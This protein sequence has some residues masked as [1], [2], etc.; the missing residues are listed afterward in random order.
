MG[1]GGGKIV[2]NDIKIKPFIHNIYIIYSMR[3]GRKSER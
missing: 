2:R 1:N 3:G